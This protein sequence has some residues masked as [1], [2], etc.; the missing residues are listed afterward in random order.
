[1]LTKKTSKNQITL[2]KKIADRFPEARYFEV[3]ATESEIV[4]RPVDLDPAR[5]VREKL[6]MLD[7]SEEDVASAVAWAR[8]RKA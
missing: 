8:E 6:R 4:L 3:R 1:M 5:R 2:P 7:L